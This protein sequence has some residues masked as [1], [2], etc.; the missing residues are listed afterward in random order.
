[1]TK[2]DFKDYICRPFCLFYK[3]GEKEEMACRGAQ[4]VEFLVNH[5]IIDP[6]KIIFTKNPQIWE[7]QSAK[8]IK[9]I[10]MR[11]SFQ[12]KDCDFQSSEPSVDIEPCGGFI[13]LACL[14]DNNI[15]DESV[16]E[17]TV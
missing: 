3:E 8:L 4:V 14:M 9:H 2:K 7:N 15:I 1:M 5:K 12:D 16:L 6:G 13:L 17:K 11:C 10:C